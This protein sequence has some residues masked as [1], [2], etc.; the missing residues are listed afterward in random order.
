[1]ARHKKTLNGKRRLSKGTVRQRWGFLHRMLKAMCTAGLVPV[2]PAAGLSPTGGRRARVAASPLDP[3]ETMTL[4]ELSRV[5][6]KANDVFSPLIE[7][8]VVLFALMGLA[9]LRVS[10]ARALQVPDIDLDYHHPKHGRMPRIRVRRSESYGVLGPPKHHSYRDVIVVPR[11]EHLLRAYMQRLK[12]GTVWLF[13]NAL[14][15][16]N[17][18][19]R[20][21]ADSAGYGL[22]AGWCVSE[23]KTR[24]AWRILM[25][26]TGL[27]R[28]LQPKSLRHAFCTIA[29]SQG[30]SL[31][32]VKCQM[33]HRDVIITQQVYGRWAQPR[34]RGQ[35]AA[36]L[37]TQQLPTRSYYGAPEA[38][39][40]L[41]Q[42]GLA[43]LP[44]RGTD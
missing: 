23:S 33:G 6:D 41:A 32:W 14:P 2:N 18:K 13:P 7:W 43:P 20:A 28:P 8:A 30:E 26:A 22:A 25:T 16:R 29:L 15:K 36:W 21:A 17:S 1:M 34:G 27:G 11:L 37:A 38:A 35:L 3:R 40:L 24:K 5:L 44:P 12:P 10:E 31:E 19:A 9:G 4:E 39:E 42:V